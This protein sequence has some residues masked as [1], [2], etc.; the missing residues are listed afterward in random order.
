[1]AEKKATDLVAG[2]G[3]QRNALQ[4]L[5]GRLRVDPEALKSTLKATAFRDCKSDAEFIS[6]VIVANTYGLNPILKELYAFPGRNGVIPIVSIDGWISLVNRHSRYN[7]VELIENDDPEGKQPGGL[8]SVT[9]KFHLKDTEHPVIVTEYMEECYNGCKEPWK[10]WPRRMLRHK[11]YIQ[12]ARI[13]FGFSGIYDEDEAQ[14][15]VE[16]QV[17]DD[18]SMKP[19]VEMPK[20]KSPN[21]GEEAAAPEAGSEASVPEATDLADLQEVPVGQVVPLIIAPLL[22]LNT[23][24]VTKKDGKKT[25]ITDYVIGDENVSATVAGWGSPAEGL[26]P[27]TIVEL[28]EVTVSEFKGERKYS[29]REIKAAVTQ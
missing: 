15:I 10:K 1:M 13:A 8:R 20:E 7:G 9:A 25:K 28:H 11:A 27:E 18:T 5:A 21:G 26:E 12:G 4:A 24:D 17:V 19:A 6:A 22:S 16:A 14:R 29:A 2:N 3:K 23:R